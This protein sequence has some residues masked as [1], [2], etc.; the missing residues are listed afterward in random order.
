MRVDAKSIPM[1]RVDQD[2]KAP[3]KLGVGVGGLR[4]GDGE[5][6]WPFRVQERDRVGGADG[7]AKALRNFAQQPFQLDVPELL[8]DVFCV[9][10]LYDQEGERPVVADRPVGL[11]AD[12][13]IDELGVPDPGHGIDDPIEGARGLVGLALAAI[14]AV[15]GSLR[16]LRIAV[17]AGAHGGI[18]QTGARISV[19]T[20]QGELFEVPA[21]AEPDAPRAPR[22]PPRS[23][24]QLVGQR[25]VVEVLRSLTAADHLP[26]IVLWG[27]PGSGKTT[28]AGL[29]AAETKARLVAMSAVTAS[30]ADL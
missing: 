29:L 8:V 30:L 1:L 23:F 25:R 27:P 19:I 15:L 26:S 21:V 2:R 22:L 24:D 5:M 4:E 3:T 11:L 9:V 10:Q 17:P 18:L 12:Q 14:W 16:Q 20:D 28:L 6:G 13:G 7:L